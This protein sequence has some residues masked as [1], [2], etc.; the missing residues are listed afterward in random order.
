MT[1]GQSNLS[2]TEATIPPLEAARRQAANQLCILLGMP[3]GR[4]DRPGR[5]GHGLVAEAT[6]Q[7]PGST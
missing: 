1:Q 3:P 7:G 5:S 6:S 2:Q 4:L